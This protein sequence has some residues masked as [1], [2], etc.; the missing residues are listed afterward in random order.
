VEAYIARHKDEYPLSLLEEHRKKTP[1]SCSD[2]RLHIREREH[3]DRLTSEAEKRLKE[4]FETFESVITDYIDYHGRIPYCVILQCLAARFLGAGILD[5]EFTNKEYLYRSSPQFS[6]MV[7]NLG[8]WCRSRFNKCPL[9]EKLQKF[10]PHLDYE[11][12]REHEKIG[13]V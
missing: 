9:P 13:Y 8:N 4:D 1:Y 10:E 11:I 12:G 7:W 2:P 5:P 3:V 6:C